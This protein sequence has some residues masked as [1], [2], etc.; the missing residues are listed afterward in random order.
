MM[1]LF[2]YS[3]QVLVVNL[4][5]KAAGVSNSAKELLF[6]GGLSSLI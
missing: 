4:I 2:S 5:G 6:S 3:L 1:F